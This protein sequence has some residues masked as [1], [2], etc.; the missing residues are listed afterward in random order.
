MVIRR[1]VYLGN[2]LNFP[3]KYVTIIS[4]FRGF[5]R[6]ADNGGCKMS[7]ETAE[8]MINFMQIAVFAGSH[9]DLPIHDCRITERRVM[10]RLL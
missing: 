8:H 9:Y 2:I 3:Y 6:T 5:L 1:K 10:G 7:A 4:E